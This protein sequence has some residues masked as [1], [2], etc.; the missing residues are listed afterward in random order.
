MGIVFFNFIWTYQL[1]RFKFP[2][3]KTVGYVAATYLADQFIFDR[4]QLKTTGLLQIYRT[5]TH[6]FSSPK[7]IN[8]HQRGCCINLQ[9]HSTQKPEQKLMTLTRQ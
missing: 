3:F 9:A 8:S 7:Y 1:F 6:F 5:L 2:F 4:N